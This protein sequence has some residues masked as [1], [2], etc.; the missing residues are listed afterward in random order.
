M[1]NKKK[2]K[3]ENTDAMHEAFIVLHDAL[4]QI[5]ESDERKTDVMMKMIQQMQQPKGN[6]LVWQVIALF[7]AIPS[8][9]MMV[10]VGISL[11]IDLMK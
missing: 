10:Y 3:T 8:T 2:Q 1:S 6:V 9:F 5:A 11:I 4:M 7:F